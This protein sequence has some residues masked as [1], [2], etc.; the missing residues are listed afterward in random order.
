MRLEIW[1]GLGNFFSGEVPLHPE[2]NFIGMEIKFKRCYNTAEKTLEKWGKNFVVVKEY[3]QKIDDFIADG[4]LE[5]TYI[6]F[7]D[8][9]AKKERQKKHRIMQKEFLEMLHKKTKA[10]GKLVFKTD[11]RGYF[12]DTLELLTTMDIWKQWVLS[13]DYQNELDHFDTKRLTEFEVIFAHEKINYL[14]L[15]KN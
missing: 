11:H 7:P 14:E 1:T 9:W 3:A 4:E 13:Y 8:P 2:K 10:G 15:I 6:F 12:D 5:Q